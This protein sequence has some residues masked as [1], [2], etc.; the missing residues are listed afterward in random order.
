MAPGNLGNL[1]AS[2]EK[3]IQTAR[4]DNTKQ[5]L[6]T[7][8]FNRWTSWAFCAVSSISCNENGLAVLLP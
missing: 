5:F 1:V 2:Y 8:K 4:K 7:T 3:I 6:K